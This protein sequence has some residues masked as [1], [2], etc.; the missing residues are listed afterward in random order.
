MVNFMLCD[1]FLNKKEMMAG[2]TI[3]IIKKK[4]KITKFNLNVIHTAIGF[5]VMPLCIFILSAIGIALCILN[6]PK[7]ISNEFC[8]SLY[9]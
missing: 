9:L 3:T 5:L 7:L 8:I 2:K 6:L 1:F 4:K